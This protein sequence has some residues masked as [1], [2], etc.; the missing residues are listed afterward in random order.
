MIEFLVFVLWTICVSGN[1]YFAR[2]AFKKDNYGWG[3]AHSVLAGLL[4]IEMLFAIR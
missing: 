3:V 4:I 1:I 2:D